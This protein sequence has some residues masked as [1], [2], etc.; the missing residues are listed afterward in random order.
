MSRSEENISLSIAYGDVQAWDPSEPEKALMRA[1]LMTAISDLKK[2]GHI[3]RK[4]KDYF[5]NPEDDYVLSFRSVCSYLNINSQSVLYA[6]GLSMG[7]NQI[8]SKQEA[9]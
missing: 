2:E 5:L 9:A 3:K 8:A 7:K 4:A 6:I 1:M